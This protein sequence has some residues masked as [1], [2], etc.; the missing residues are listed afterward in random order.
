ML[1]ETKRRE[2]D[3]QGVFYTSQASYFI[4]GVSDAHVA[5]LREGKE[6]QQSTAREGERDAE[7]Q[8]DELVVA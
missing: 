3:P 5:A 8:T 7:A 2:V 6:V 1:F 4:D